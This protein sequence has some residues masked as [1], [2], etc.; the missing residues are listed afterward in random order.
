MPVTPLLGHRVTFFWAQNAE[1]K[2]GWSENFWSSLTD[3][4]V[5]QTK[6]L[7]LRI[8]LDNIHGSQTKCNDIRISVLG[9]ARKVKLISIAGGPNANLTTP[10]VSDFPSTALQLRLTS[11]A[12]DSTTQWIRGL[13]DRDVAKGGRKDLSADTV[14]AFA[15]L[16][17]VLISGSN[18]WAM[19]I[20]D[21]NRA[22]KVITGLTAAG[23]VNSVGHGFLVNDNVRISRVKGLIQAN[24]IW[25]VSSVTANTFT[26]AGWV[27]ENP[28]PVYLGG[29]IVSLQQYAFTAI[30][31]VEAVR[32]TSHKTGRPFGL[33]GGRPKRRPIMRV[34]LVAAP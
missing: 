4:G 11:A 12:N 18:G 19:R 23:E 5:V 30:A 9:A 28:S 8:A 26:L 1:K 31:E 2:F 15:A 3:T 22:L 21:P 33:A 17:A 25:R 16:K 34:G 6:A 10:E 24:R 20:L 14:T 29:G 27:T 32:A 13:Q 7:A